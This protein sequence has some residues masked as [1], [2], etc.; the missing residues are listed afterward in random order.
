VNATACQYAVVRFAPFVETG[1]FAN[2]G[3]LLLAPRAGFFGHEI[4]TRRYARITRF[5]EEMD[6]QTYKA[7]MVTVGTELG[8]FAEL[9]R[10]RG[11]GANADRGAIVFAQE[12]FQEIIR[13]R[14]GIVRY[15]AARVVMA[16]DP[17]TTLHE[18][19]QHYVERSFAT[20][21]YQET[22]LERGLRMLLQRAQLAV[23]FESCRVGDDGFHVNFPLVEMR[24]ETPVKAIK[25][26]NLAQTDP[27]KIRDHAILWRARIDKLRA[28]RTLPERVLFALSEPGPD[29][30]QR[31]AYEEARGDLEAA[32]V[33]LVA[34]RDNARVL[35]FAR[36]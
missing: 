7:A 34:A 8:H 1:E 9:V 28:R 11:L 25:A 35:E 5:F 6:A 13:P 19:F 14:E 32:E 22:V 24:G 26:L 30:A 18:L 4:Q 16:A 20:R 21:E 17:S 15:S 33:Q 12:V 36:A 2:V 23:R 3:I 27:S 31:D 10:E 29:G